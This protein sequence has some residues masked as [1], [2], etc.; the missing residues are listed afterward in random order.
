MIQSRSIR[1][2]LVVAVALF[3]TVACASTRTQKSMGEQIDDTMITTKVK[4][5]LIGDPLTKAHEIDVEVFKGRVQL[6]G[7]VRTEAM[8]TQAVALARRVNGVVAV[9]NNLKL[10]QSGERTDG[11][12]VDDNTL[13]A[14]VKSALASDTRTNAF[15]INVEI[16][17]SVVLLAGFV[18]S[19]EGR[20]AAGEVARAVKGVARVDNQL[21]VK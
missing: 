14:S 21:A 11:D 4:A 13:T 12:V 2:A 7:F 20:T 5:E 18:N 1:A 15:R 17:D 8:R 6:N 10:K 19:S 9:D 3:T 16:R